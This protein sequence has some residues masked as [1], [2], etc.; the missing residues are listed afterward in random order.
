MSS[1]FPCVTPGV[2]KFSLSFIASK[3][4]EFST[5]VVFVSQ[6]ADARSGIWEHFHS[7]S[8]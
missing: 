7:F 4:A 3:V 6:E 1:R 2:W 5:C 8:S